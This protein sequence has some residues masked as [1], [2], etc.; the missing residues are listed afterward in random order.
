MVTD[1]PIG[2]CCGDTLDGGI[3][4]A[5]G[6]TLTAMAFAAVLL[7]FSS[8]TQ[9]IVIDAYRIECI[10][11]SFQAMLSSMYIAGYRIGMVVAG[12]GALFLASFFGTTKET[13]L[14]EAW[15]NT[16]WVMAC[17]MGVGIVTTLVISEPESNRDP[18]IYGYS[19]RS[20]L[21]LF[22]CFAIS[23]IAFCM[24]FF[25]AA[26]SLLFSAVTSRTPGRCM[27]R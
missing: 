6:G 22:L 17:V 7:G 25:S 13:Y 26:I 3:N 19:G 12:A 16:Y 1:C 27:S 2:C 10:D 23:C 4:P 15:R 9:D 18:A 8:A 11:E 5:N 21:R 24:V 20:Y 14:Y